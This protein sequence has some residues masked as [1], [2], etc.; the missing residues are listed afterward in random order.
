VIRFLVANISKSRFLVNLFRT[1]IN[2]V[3][4][5]AAITKALLMSS[6]P[7]NRWP[8]SSREEEIFKLLSRAHKETRS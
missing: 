4:A 3:P 8:Y 7:E 5:F 6:S 1:L 2:R